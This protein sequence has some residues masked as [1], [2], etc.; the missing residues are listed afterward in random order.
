[1]NRKIV[2]AGMASLMMLG[3]IALAEEAGEEAAARNWESSVGL[4]YLATSGNSDT[5][6]LGVEF[7]YQRQPTPWGYSV[8]ASYSRAEENSVT[9][10]ERTFLGIRGE[11]RLN[12][13]W[14]IFAG[15]NGER[16]RFAGFD[17][18]L[19]VESG[20]EWKA[21]LGPTHTLSLD[22]GLTWTTEDRLSETTDSV[23]GILGLAY[24]WKISETASLK[25]RL[26][27]YPNFDESDDWR[28]TSETSLEASL[29]QRLAVK[30]G[31]LVR[32]DNLPVVGFDD[33]DTTAQVSLVVH[34]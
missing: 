28:L 26:A 21:L 2:L 7:T 25:Q 33:T 23:G 29:T 30:I 34:L 13:R 1:M 14:N 5:E 9:T 24:K 18:R 8:Q 15:V 31:Y 22:A 3:G 12:E 6:T 27:Y 10:T 16:D 4:S 19:I 32:Y 20:G 11:R 17:S